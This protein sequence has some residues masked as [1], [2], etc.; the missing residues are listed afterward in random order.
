[1]AHRSEDDEKVLE[2]ER[3]RNSPDGEPTG[4]HTGRCGNCGSKD[5][6]ED[7]IAYGCNSCGALL[8]SN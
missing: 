1:M 3:R 6:W 2:A 5:L 4:S 7:N 8:G